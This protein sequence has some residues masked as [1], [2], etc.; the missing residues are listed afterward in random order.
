MDMLREYFVHIYK[1]KPMYWDCHSS[2]NFCQL[3]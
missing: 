3:R 2:F 1:C